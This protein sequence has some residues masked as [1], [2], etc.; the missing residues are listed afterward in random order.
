MSQITASMVKDLREK[1]GAGM[2]DCKKALTE[3]GADL[4]KAIDWLRQKGLA[5]AAKRADRAAEEGVII[6]KVA[7]D[8]KKA[9]AV[10][11]KCET[12]FVARGDKF[13]DFAKDVVNHAF[14]NFGASSEEIL[15]K[16][17]KGTTLKEAIGEAVAA[18]GENI[19]LGKTHNAEC[20]EGIVGTYVHSNGKLAALVEVKAT[21]NEAAAIDFAKN[22]AMQVVAANPIALDMASVD[23]A[24]LEREREVY[25]NKAKEEGKPDNIIDK[26]ADGAVK[27][28]CKEICLME[29]AYIR[30]DKMSIADLQKQASKDAGAEFTIVGFKRLVLG[31]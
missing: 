8:N 22:V 18:I 24:L 20:A 19:L 5:K 25:K 21:G 16:P 6:L 2:M 14:D 9:V 11:V 1:T 3:S 15:E 26:I 27:K 29:Q 28:Y 13:I 17:F 10:E 7:D 31:E 12:D 30:D 4:E 23:P